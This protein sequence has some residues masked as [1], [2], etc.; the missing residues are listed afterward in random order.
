MKKIVC[1]FLATAISMTFFGCSK[2]KQKTNDDIKNDSSK[3]TETSN[4]NNKTSSLPTSLTTS[5]NNSQNETDDKK[6]STDS[7]NSQQS[8]SS[9]VENNSSSVSKKENEIVKVTFPEGTTLP[10]MF[11]ILEQ[12]G[13]AKQDDLFAEAAKFNIN[14]FE[15]TS[16]INTSK[17][18]CF[19][20]EGYLFPDT[21]DF[22]VG[23]TP[24]SIL[25]KMVS[26][27]QKRLSS[28]KSQAAKT[29]LSF[30]EIM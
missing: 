26:N 5:K 3:S 19:K 11:M 9:N 1:L 7:K 6:S 13:V 16:G 15:I 2:P 8:V 29:G 17:A 27:S 10:K 12:K 4:S 20:L 28:L 25:K 18:R 24:T 30:D 23:E 14:S 22:F 21:Y